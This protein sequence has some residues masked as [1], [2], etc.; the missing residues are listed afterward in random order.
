MNISSELREIEEK[1][2]EL[3]RRRKEI[4]R[5]LHKVEEDASRDGY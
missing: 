2:E 5:N 1:Q 3:L 4:L